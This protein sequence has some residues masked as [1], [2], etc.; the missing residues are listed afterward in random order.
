MSKKNSC[1]GSKAK[2]CFGYGARLRAQGAREKDVLLGRVCAW[3]ALIFYAEV[4]A[5]EEALAKTPACIHRY[6]GAGIFVLNEYDDTIGTDL[7]KS[8]LSSL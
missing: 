3:P 7:F 4:L 2:G 1:G 5:Q 8:P 6:S